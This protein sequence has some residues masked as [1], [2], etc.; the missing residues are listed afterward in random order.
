MKVFITKANAYQI[1][2]SRKHRNYLDNNSKAFSHFKWLNNAER[3][4]FLGFFYLFTNPEKILVDYK[5]IDETYYDSKKYVFSS[6]PAYH[7]YQDCKRLQSSFKNYVIPDEIREK[8]EGE[9]TEFKNFFIDNEELLCYNQDAFNMRLKFK[10]SLNTQAKMVNYENSGVQEFE[11]FNLED[12]KRKVRQILNDTNSFYNSSV[13]HR[14]ILDEFGHCAFIGKQRIP[15][16]NNRTEYDN[17]KIW[18]ILEDFDENFKKKYQKHF[19]NL[20]RISK[21]PNLEFNSGLLDEL[22][23]LPC[24]SCENKHLTETL[25]KELDK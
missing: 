12:L 15:P 16:Q 22:G 6:Q 2:H 7:R 4:N 10:F 17:E 20:M 1:I 19:I 24:Q 23:L 3:S 9:I 14:N 11:N 25:T 8:G 18:S 5:R 21:N 13:A